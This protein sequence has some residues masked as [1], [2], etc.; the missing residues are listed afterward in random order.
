MGEAAVQ[1]YGPFI[2]LALAVSTSTAIV[3]NRWRGS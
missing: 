3:L 1:W 2:P